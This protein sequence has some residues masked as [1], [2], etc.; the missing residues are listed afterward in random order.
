MANITIAESAAPSTPAT[1]YAAIYVKSDGLLYWKD[2]AGTEY[3]VFYSAANITQPVNVQEFR[4]TLTTAT[5]VTT[6][7]VTADR[8][9]V[10]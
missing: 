5:P 9:S 10:V 7:D 8:K 2:D 1:G 4:L 6:S 3:P